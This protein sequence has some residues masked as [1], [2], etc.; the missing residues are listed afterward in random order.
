MEGAT[1]EKVKAILGKPS[2]LATD[3]IVKELLG[4]PPE[5]CYIVG[6]R[7]ETDIKMGNDYGIQSVLVLTGITDQ[8]MLDETFEKPRFV[9]DSI[10]EVVTL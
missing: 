7:L 6:D 5:Q 3:F 9:L 8:A 1:G 4:I 2:L 10:K